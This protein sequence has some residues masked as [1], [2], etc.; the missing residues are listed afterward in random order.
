MVIF[1]MIIIGV[2][3]IC[4]LLMDFSISAVVMNATAVKVAH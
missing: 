3:F 2:L 4:M 1:I